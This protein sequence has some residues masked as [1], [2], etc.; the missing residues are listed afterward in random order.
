M[1][2][3]REG[4]LDISYDGEVRPGLAPQTLALFKTDI[5]D[6]LTLFKTE[7]RFLIPCL[8]QSCGDKKLCGFLVV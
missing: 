1:K 2:F 6:F 5:A 7:L 8:R 3:P 4:V